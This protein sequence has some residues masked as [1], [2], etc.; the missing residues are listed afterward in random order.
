MSVKTYTSKDATWVNAAG[1]LVP[2]KFV[3]LID[4]QKEK[5]AATLLADALSIEGKLLK[6]HAAMHLATQQVSALVKQEYAIK[7]GKEKKEGKGSITWYNFDKSI[8]I[9]ADVN[10]LVKWDSA[11]MTE[12]LHL[13]QQYLSGSLSDAQMLIKDMVSDGFSNSKGMIDSRRI[14]QLLKYESKIKDKRFLSACELIK[15]AQSIDTTKLYMRIWVK[16]D[17]GGYRNVNLNFSSI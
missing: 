12:A 7:Q 3:P 1:D 8:K 5:V 17:K 2:Y 13:L 10:D 9:E 16:D 15:Q 11:L 14:F 6:L 4:R